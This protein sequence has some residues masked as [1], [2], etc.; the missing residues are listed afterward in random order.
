MP[1]TRPTSR[2]ACRPR[3]T[4]DEYLIFVTN[5]YA[6]EGDSYYGEAQGETSYANN[7]YA[8]PIT[9]SAPDLTIKTASAPSTVTVGQSISV[10][11][12][13][14]NI[15]AVE[16]PGDWY[17]AVYV[18]SSPTFNA[19][20]DTYV[21]SFS[22]NSQ[23]PLAAGASY[24]ANELI[25]LS[26]V[27]TGD[28][29][30]IFVTNYYAVEGD[31]YYGEAQGET[32]YANNTYAVPITVS[33]PDLTIK[34]ASA[35][36]TVIVG[37]SISVSWTVQNIGTV[38]AP[39]DWYDA[40]YVGS[41]PTFN[42]NT[43]TY[44]EDFYEGGQSPLAASASYTAN[45]SIDLS[46]VPAG[47]DYLIFVTN[48]EGVLNEFYFGG[49]Q[50]ESTY[51]NN[52]YAVPITISAPDLT[53]TTATAPSTTITGQAISVSWAVQ[54]IGAVEAPGD[55]YDAVYVGSSPT[56]NASSDT[57]VTSFAESSQSPLAAN[58]SYTDNESITLPPTATATST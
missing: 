50:A 46:S 37:Q 28:E 44:V 5:Y 55:W 38:Q 24:T 57:Y 36:P 22:E 8:V 29:Y 7:T 12:T 32:S 20:S 1:A 25:S 51:T 11:W 17:D 3:A 16:A 52:T 58:A 27:P 31:S 45:A 35:P 40:V 26:S 42:S 53:I 9:V 19:S 13:V 49:A 48:Y 54:N 43:D 4:G 39:A 21:T 41:S 23:S 18:G 2:S 47:D 33:A 14:Q 56:F 34:T 30:L 6:V 10:S 15:G